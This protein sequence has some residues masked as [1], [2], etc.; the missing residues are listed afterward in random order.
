MENLDPKTDP[1][2]KATQNTVE[3][4]DADPRSTDPVRAQ[5]TAFHRNWTKLEKLLLNSL[6][7][8]RNFKMR[9]SVRSFRRA[10]FR[11]ARDPHGLSRSLC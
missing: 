9:R 10:V 4:C 11:T 1:K 2:L 6:V 3:V 5:L 8:Q 7:K